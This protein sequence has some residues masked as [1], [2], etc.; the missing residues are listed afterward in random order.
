[1]AKKIESFMYP[2]QFFLTEENGEFRFYKEDP[3][4]VADRVSVR[5]DIG[6]VLA[7]YVGPCDVGNPLVLKVRVGRIDR[8]RGFQATDPEKIRR[9]IL[10]G[11]F[12]DFDGN[13]VEILPG[14]TGAFEFPFLGAVVRKDTKEAVG[15]RQYSVRGECMDGDTNHRIV[16][17]DGLL[18]IEFPKDEK[19]G[20]EKPEPQEEEKKTAGN[21]AD[22]NGE[23]PA[24]E[25]VEKR[26]PRRRSRPARKKEESE[27]AGLFGD[28]DIEKEKLADEEE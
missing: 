11:H 14:K 16:I 4:T 3:M 28:G 18:H 1:M 26:T 19:E 2:E 15:F 24:G 7:D 27:D 21:S 12:E 25:A 6:Q 5:V 10:Q 22:G 17:V 13:Y 20:E 8:C 23:T 9:G